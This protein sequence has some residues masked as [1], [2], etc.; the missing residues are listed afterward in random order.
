MT[1]RLSQS[2]SIF[3]TPAIEKTADYYAR[4][5]GFRAVR[6]LAASE[7]HICLYRDDME[8]VLTDSNG[9]KVLPNRELYGY[10]YDVYLISESLED[11]QAELSAAGAKIVRTL[12]MTDYQNREFV[13]EDID[14]RWIAFGKKEQS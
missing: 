10:G 4:V 1:K 9:K 14:G 8:I 6:Y 7:P 11:L 12:G 13:L 2:I 5:L 3:P